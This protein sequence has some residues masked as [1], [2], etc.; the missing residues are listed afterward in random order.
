MSRALPAPFP[1]PEFPA[2]NYLNRE[3]GLL[4]FNRRVFAQAQ[5]PE[6]PLLER[7]RFLCIVSS[8]LDEFFEIRAAGLKEQIKLNSSARSTD[9]KSA[10]KPIGSLPT[11]PCPGRGAVRTVQPRH[12][13]PAGR[14]R[15]LF[16]AAQCLD[17]G[18]AEWIHDY[19]QKEVMPVL[20]PIGLDPSHPLPARPQQEPQLR[21]RARRKGR[22]RAQ[23]GA[24]IVQAPRMLPR[25]IQLPEA[26]AG[27]RHGFVFLS[28]ILHGFVG[29][30]FAGM[31]V[32]A[33]T[34]SAS[35]AT[36]T[37]SS[38]RRKS[39][40][41]VPRSRANSS[42]P[43]RRRRSPRGCGELLAG[44]DPFPARAVRPR[45]TRAVSRRRP[46]QPCPPD[47][48]TGQRRPPG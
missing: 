35:R 45:R 9:G 31:E 6:T 40:T 25:V 21:G 5:N 15:H 14:R 42:A 47:A 2:G 1:S 27:C 44:N 7:L 13:S 48:G 30:L 37:F 20:T 46:G 10:R 3:L 4:A 38:T 32:R 17:R 33:A 28:S 12:P 41:C 29:D 36:P 11:R 23:F 22:L 24:A 19:F 8:N 26:L 34:S 43:F 39:R 16:P 18:A